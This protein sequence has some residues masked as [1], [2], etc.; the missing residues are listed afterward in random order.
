MHPVLVEF[1]GLTLYVYGLMMAVSF[2]LGV[3]LCALRAPRFGLAREQVYDAVLP[4]ILCSLAGAKLL[5][6]A[7]DWRLYLA[8]PRGL[9]G[10]IRGGFVFYGGLAGGIAGGIWWLRRRRLPVLAFGDLISAPLALAQVTG[11]LGCFFNGCCYGRAVEGG[12]VFPALGDG[13]PRHP[14]QLYE[15]AGTAIIGA[16]LLLRPAP[17]RTKPGSTLGWYAV[18]YALLRFFV[19]FFRDD[20]RGPAFAGFT[21]S[22][23]MA[24]AAFGAGLALILRPVTLPPAP[25]AS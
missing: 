1:G 2:A 12:I 21:V 19:E 8:D 5:Y 18:S 9:M 7:Q 23:T 4:I 22:Q 25:P 20:P 13:A 10:A 15:A 3:W 14:T 11:R 17:P 24:I 16:L 6:L